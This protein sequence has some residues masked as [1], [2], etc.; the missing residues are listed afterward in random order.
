MIS[1]Q[2]FYVYLLT[3]W[4]NQ[5]MYVGVINDLIRRVYEHKHNQLAGFTA[6]YNLNKLVYFEETMDIKSALLRE[7]QI[8]KWRREK[9]NRLVEEMNPGWVDLSEGWYEA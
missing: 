3:N 8:K 9:K 1:D 5:V 6:K 4:N 7:K 2:H